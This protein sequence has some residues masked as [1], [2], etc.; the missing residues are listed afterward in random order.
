MYFADY[1]N[2][3]LKKQLITKWVREA[4]RRRGP[5]IAALAD[6]APSCQLN[7]T[8]AFGARSALRRLGCLM[9]WR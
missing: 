6:V 3:N 4:G 5:S 9:A 7:F 2:T 8:S 1:M